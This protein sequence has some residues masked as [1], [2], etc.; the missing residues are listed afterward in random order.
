MTHYPLFI[1]I[2][3][4]IPGSC[5]DVPLN[6]SENPVTDFLY[7][8]VF[9]SSQRILDAVFH[10]CL[11]VWSSSHKKAIK[12]QIPL[13]S[14]RTLKASLES[15][16]SLHNWP[17]FSLILSQRRSKWIFFRGIYRSPHCLE[18]YFKRTS[19][20]LFTDLI[21]SIL[22]GSYHN[23]LTKPILIMAYEKT[24]P[25]RHFTTAIT[26]YHIS[27]PSSLRTSKKPIQRRSFSS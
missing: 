6:N 1:Y 21:L 4:R 19:S 2:R 13:G 20:I 22:F 12:N 16:D 14:I 23:S 15:N 18:G 26:R 25:L 27:S 11:C 17:R 9:T 24:L 3:R 5:F 10:L 8:W 7:L